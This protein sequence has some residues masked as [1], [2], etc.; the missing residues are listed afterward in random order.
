M[1]DT[2]GAVARD[3]AVLS[4]RDRRAILQAL[5]ADD[6]A[7]VRAVMRGTAPAAANPAGVATLHSPWVEQLAADARNGDDGRMTGAA[8][9]A[10]LEAL[11]RSRVAPVRP[12]GRSLLQAAGGLLGQA[13][14]R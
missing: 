4:G 12:S 7:T 3:L 13:I 9:A 11:D 8:R 6:R 14:A 1:P 2:L 5:D 10:L